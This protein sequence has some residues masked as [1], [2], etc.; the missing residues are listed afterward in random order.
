M[1]YIKLLLLWIKR[2]YLRAKF[3]SWK[4]KVKNPSL[5]FFEE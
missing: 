2:S 1:F 5:P 3:I 4:F